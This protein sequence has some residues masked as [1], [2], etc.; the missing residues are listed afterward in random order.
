MYLS[1]ISPSP[2]VPCEAHTASDLSAQVQSC[3]SRD[4]CLILAVPL[5][6]YTQVYIASVGELALVFSLSGKA[7]VLTV[8][9]KP[10]YDLAMPPPPL[11]SVTSSAAPPLTPL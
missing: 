11:I 5:R 8:V 9:Y 4:G 2:H 1:I 10:L 3:Q 6:C 7:R